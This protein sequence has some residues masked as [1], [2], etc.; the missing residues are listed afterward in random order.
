MGAVL[1]FIESH[2]ALI[3]IVV[4]LLAGIGFLIKHFFFSEKKASAPYI[5][6]GGNISAGGDIVL[7]NKNADAKFGQKVIIGLVAIVLIVVLFLV[8]LYYDQIP[9]IA[10]EVSN[11]IV[12]TKG[13]N[14]IYDFDFNISTKKS[15]VLLGDRGM[16]VNEHIN[17]SLGLHPNNPGD[18]KRLGFREGNFIVGDSEKILLEKAVSYSTRYRIATKEI[19]DK[20][21]IKYIVDAENDVTK[22]GL[23]AIFQSH[24]KYRLV[25][26]IPIDFKN[27]DKQKGY[28]KNVN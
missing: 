7:G 9:I 28:F 6:A 11:K 2:P 1:K 10:Y 12:S 20:I 26:E 25:A 18:L 13:D 27:P 16:A 24:Y 14:Y 22:L 17:N 15:N 4:L 19:K 8:W 3:T 21:S 23:I 5:K